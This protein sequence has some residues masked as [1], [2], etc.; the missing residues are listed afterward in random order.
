[1]KDTKLAAYAK[2]REELSIIEGTI[3]MNECV[4][5]P[6]ILRQKVL[7]VLHKGHPGILRMKELA[8]QY[9]YWPQLTDEVEQYVRACNP[10]A[11]AQKLPVKEPLQP[12]PPTS[13][14]LER[15][16]I[17]YAGP[18]NNQYLLIFVD[19]F[20]KFIEVEVTNTIS[21]ERTVE[22]CR[23]FVSRYGAPEMIVSD[24]G[25]Q[26]TSS[27]FRG[28]CQEVGISHLF[29]PVGHPQ[30]N[31]QA[32][33]MVD[34]VKRA[35]KKEP[36]EWKKHLQEFLFSYHYTPCSAAPEGK[37]PA[38]IFFGRTIR[39]PLSALLPPKIQSP[40]AKA[41][42]QASDMKQQFDQHHG[43]QRQNLVVGDNVI[44]QLREGQRERGRLEKVAAAN[45]SKVR[46]S[47]G[48][49]VERH[50]NHM[51][52]GGTGPDI[53]HCPRDWSPIRTTKRTAIPIRPST[54][55][56][57]SYNSVVSSPTTS[58]NAGSE[59]LEPLQ[60]EPHDMPQDHHQP[61][62][63]NILPEPPQDHDWAQIGALRKTEEGKPDPEVCP[64]GST[65]ENSGPDDVTNEPNEFVRKS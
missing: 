45:K 39:S 28:F 7:E 14:P 55:E 4:V 34:T 2:R 3:M 15:V 35:I 26:F 31:G 30:S 29:S 32:E 65:V 60:Q 41:I 57:S 59:T 6:K 51:W 5:I 52:R 33:R 53:Q 13:R 17:D 64:L 58:I 44:V 24:N 11:L 8:R 20:S 50:R 16:H 23:E 10:C 37:P 22:L 48:R 18:I 21:A 38:D 61:G 27:L 56:T 42:A 63:L 40:S 19:A 47:D 9:V 43:A 12:W 62:A 49:L 36:N 1:M 54:P 25:T 46:L